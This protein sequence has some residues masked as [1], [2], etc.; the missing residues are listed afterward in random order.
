MRGRTKLWILGLWHIIVGLV[1]TLAAIEALRGDPQPVLA[2]LYVVA[3]GLSAA[4][5][6]AWATFITTAEEGGGR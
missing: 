2:T 6:L 3:F 1:A 5:V 4:M